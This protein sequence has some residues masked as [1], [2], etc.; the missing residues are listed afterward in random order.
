[1][2]AI[3]CL[4]LPYF[5]LWFSMVI[6]LSV[7]LAPFLSVLFWVVLLNFLYLSSNAFHIILLYEADDGN[8]TNEVER[9]KMAKKAHK[10]L[11]FAK[12]IDH[13]YCL[14]R[15]T[16]KCWRLIYFFVL[17]S[18]LL[19]IITIIMEFAVVWRYFS[20]THR[21]GIQSVTRT[22]NYFH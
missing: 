8:P 16:A 21:L 7:L 13:L 20:I 19:A 14:H 1:M 9:E 11:S 5:G 4:R 2:F 18:Y 10:K 15:S 17:C 3:F 6:R 22:L 12:R